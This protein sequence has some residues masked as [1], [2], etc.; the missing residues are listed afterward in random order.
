MAKIRLKVDR[1][2]KVSSTAIVASIDSIVGISICQ[3][4]TSS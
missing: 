3:L 1:P 4:N 2:Q